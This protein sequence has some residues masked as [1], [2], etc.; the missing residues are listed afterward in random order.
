MLYG[1]LLLPEGE[2]I[3]TI[4]HTNIYIDFSNVLWQKKM[5]VVLGVSCIGGFMLDVAATVEYVPAVFVDLVDRHVLDDEG[6]DKL[7]PLED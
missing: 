5:V 2:A 3:T 4:L 1:C 7:A 6:A